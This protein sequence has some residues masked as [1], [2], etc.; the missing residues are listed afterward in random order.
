MEQDDNWLDYNFY[1]CQSST[2]AQCDFLKKSQFTWTCTKLTEN[3]GDTTRNVIAKELVIRN[4]Q[5][6]GCVYAK[7]TQ[8]FKEPPPKRA[9]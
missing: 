7:F 1:K 9:I 5:E 8:F 4:P 3:Q 6:F 2:K